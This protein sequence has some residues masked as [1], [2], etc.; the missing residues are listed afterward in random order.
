MNPFPSSPKRGNTQM[1][2]ESERKGHEVENP[3]P[4]AALPYNATCLVKPFSF[5]VRN[6]KAP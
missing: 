3:M 5:R 6:R 1:R 2:E 4:A